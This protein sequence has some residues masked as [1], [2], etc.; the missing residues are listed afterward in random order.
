MLRTN[1]RYGTNLGLEDIN[2]WG[3]SSSDVCKRL[4]W[5]E[6]AEFFRTRPLITGAQDFVHQ[7]LSGGN[8]EVMIVTAIRLHFAH[9]RAKK[10]RDVFP[11]IKPENTLIGARKDVI[12]TTML[13]DD[14]P[15]NVLKSIVDYSVLFRR[16]WNSHMTGMLSV[17]NYRELLAMVERI[18]R[19]FTEWGKRKEIQY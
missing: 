9:I 8:R 14:K 5:L 10:I 6:D 18:E 3:H 7:L 11:D 17:N 2:S 4:E 12:R 1:E 16:P 15:E 13:L 19:N